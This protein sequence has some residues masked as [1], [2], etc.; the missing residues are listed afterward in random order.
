[1]PKLSFSTGK[2]DSEGSPNIYKQYNYPVYEN[3]D[4]ICYC[5]TLTD[6]QKIVE[7]LNNAEL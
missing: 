7:V 1:M 4:V 6:A 3:G 2:K 5:A